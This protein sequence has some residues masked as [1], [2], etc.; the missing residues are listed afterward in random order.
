MIDTIRIKYV[1][2]DI[3][4]YNKCY[5]AVDSLARKESKTDAL[6]RTKKKHIYITTAF[7]DY[8]LFEIRFFKQ[9]K[10]KANVI[11]LNIKPSRIISPKS[12]LLLSNYDKDYDFVRDFLN[13]FFDTI[14]DLAKKVI[15]PHVED[16]IVS[17]IDYAFDIE[18]PYVRE[19]INFF[20]RGS[21]PTKFRNFKDYDTSI[22]LT[23]KQCRIN[24]SRRCK[25]NN[26][27]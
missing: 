18:T 9:D 21:I 8:G 24:F 17:R 12:Y 15:L 1:F 3:I 7:S 27:L 10:F 11:Q 23:S 14:N 5:S 13:K 19:Y 25:F 4:D 16:W 22:Y 6:H 20:K 2:N 26:D